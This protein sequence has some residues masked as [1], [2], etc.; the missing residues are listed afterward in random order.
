MQSGRRSNLQAADNRLP[1]YARNDTLIIV[2]ASSPDL[3]GRR[4]NLQATDNR[5]PRYARND[6]PLAMR[7]ERGEHKAPR[8]PGCGGAQRQVYTRAGFAVVLTC[9]Y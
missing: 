5:L 3:S 2:F 6:T 1:R 7:G 4:S 8:L 9:Y